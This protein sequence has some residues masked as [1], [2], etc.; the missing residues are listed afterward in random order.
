VQAYESSPEL[1]PGSHPDE[2]RERC[3]A[4]ELA[5]HKKFSPVTEFEVYAYIDAAEAFRDFQ[6]YGEFPYEGGR[7]DQPQTWIMAMDCMF[8]AQ[9]EGQARASWDS[10][11][12]SEE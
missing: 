12:D 7:L 8:A 9:A 1:Y 11:Q 4:A 6:R 10:R 2:V 3:R 5:V